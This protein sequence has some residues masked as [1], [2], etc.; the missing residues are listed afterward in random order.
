[1]DMYNFNVLDVETFRFIDFYLKK[2]A[3]EPRQLI[4]SIVSLCYLF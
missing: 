1:M 4:N 3:N 2:E